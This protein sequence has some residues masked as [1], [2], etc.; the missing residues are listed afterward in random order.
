MPILG[1]FSF[2]WSRL[3][4]RSKP[5]NRRSGSRAS[6]Q[7]ERKPASKTPRRKAEP[8]GII[9]RPVPLA[10]V[11]RRAG[12]PASRKRASGA[13]NR[14]KRRHPEPDR[15]HPREHRTFSPEMV[16]ALCSTVLA[17]A[18]VVVTAF[19]LCVAAR[20]PQSAPPTVSDL[21]PEIEDLRERLEVLEDFLP[22]A[23]IAP[24]KE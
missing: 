16:F 14:V 4:Q 11:N 21:L 5:T 3:T 9:D 10:N 19:A 2:A 7:R 23:W 15:I 13:A 17:L 18:G 24:L 22:Y 20:E 8:L 12:P 1:L 6:S